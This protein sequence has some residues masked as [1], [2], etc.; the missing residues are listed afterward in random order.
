ML[1]GSIRGL[2]A[3]A[4]PL[5]ELQAGGRWIDGRVQGETLLQ[6]SSPYPAITREAVRIPN[7]PAITPEHTRG[8]AKESPAD[9]H[10]RAFSQE[11]H[12]KPGSSIV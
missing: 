11:T 6:N 12:T 3:L 10:G 4:A 9:A 8:H 2:R 7:G 1:I 5:S